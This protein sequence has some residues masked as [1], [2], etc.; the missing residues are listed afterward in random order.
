MPVFRW[1]VLRERGYDWWIARLRRN[2]ELFDLVRLDHFRAFTAY[3]E[4]PAG[5]PNAIRGKWRE[6]PGAHFF[7]V[8]KKALGSLPFVAEDLGDIDEVVLAL[9]DQ[10]GLPGMKVLQFAFGPDY[11]QSDYIPHNYT[12]NFIV[13]TGTHDNNTT[14]GWLRQEADESVRARLRHYLGKDVSE[15]NVVEH[16][17]QL[18]YGSVARMA[19]L[20]LQDVLGL[21]EEARMNTPASGSGNWEWRL[22]PGQLT[23]EA[24]DRLRH[25]TWLYNRM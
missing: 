24:G 1:S 25:W 2:M 13:Y 17:A 6:G 18:A 23:P 12:P 7:K 16:L 15:E 14:R 8:V 5:E 22:R 3:W 21:G 9:R 4:V 10:F 20:P 19:I 11:T